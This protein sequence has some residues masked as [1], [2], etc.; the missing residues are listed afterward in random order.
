MR[1]LDGQADLLK[2]THRAYRITCLQPQILS[3]S[4]I[5]KID[6]K[7]LQRHIQAP[8]TDSRELGIAWGRHLGGGPM[9]R[10]GSLGKAASE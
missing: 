7:V 3:L 8:V 6:G 5:A 10:V 4:H 2:P 1:D 9:G